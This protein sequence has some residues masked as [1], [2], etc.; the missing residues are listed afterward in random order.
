M[1][2]EVFEEYGETLSTIGSL[3]F[4]AMMHGYMA[5][6]AEDELLVPFRTW[7]NAITEE[8]EGKLTKAFRFNIPQRWS[9]AHFYQ[10]ILNKEKHVENVTF[11]TTLAGYIHWQLSGEKVLGVGDASGMFPIDVANKDYDQKKMAIFNHLVQKENM[12]ITIKSLLPRVLVAGE[13]AGTLTQEGA[14]LLD[15]TGTLKAGIPLYPPEGAAGTGM[16]A[17]NSVA[18]RTGMYLQKPLPD[19]F[20]K[21]SERGSSRNR[22]SNNANW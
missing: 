7:R 20:R 5:F 1:A 15:P 16:V 9:I 21:G 14:Y 8:T 19:R 18:K 12:S 6:D 3:G 22:S 2:A 11:L 13:A 10:A 4:S 17:T